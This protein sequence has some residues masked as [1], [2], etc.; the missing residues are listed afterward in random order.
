MERLP[1]GGQ[2]RDE[3]AAEGGRVAGREPGG[4]SL[5]QAT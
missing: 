1:Q 4:L 2:E 3:D 5:E